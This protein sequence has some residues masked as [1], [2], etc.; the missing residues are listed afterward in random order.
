MI[1]KNYLLVFAVLALIALANGIYA[2]SL[3]ID[4]IDSPEL[5]PGK[6]GVLRISVENNLNE[7]VEDVSLSLDVKGL[8][9]IIVGSSETSVDE[10]NEDDSEDF[11][12]LLRAGV[13]ATAGDY[14]IPFSLTYKN[15]TKAKTG[16]IGIRIEGSVDLETSIKTDNAIVGKKG[17]ISIKIINKG[18]AEARYVSVKL[19]ENGFLIESEEQVYIGDIDANDFETASFDVIFQK[20]N[21]GVSAEI[22]YKD[23]DNNNQRKFIDEQIKVYTL[24]EAIEKGIVSKNNFGTYIIVIILIIVLWLIWKAIAKRRRIR[25]SRQDMNGAK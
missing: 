5:M 19:A 1:N 6:E 24:E 9:I 4:G 15:S 7:D 14:Q 12:F 11:V 16:T 21:P 25:R 10:I 2:Q 22:E 23:F 3:N 8:P 18:F 17:K 20:K 13:T